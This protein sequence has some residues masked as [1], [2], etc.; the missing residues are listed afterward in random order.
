[1]LDGSSV[2]ALRGLALQ[3]EEA[4]GDAWPVAAEREVVLLGDVAVALGADAAQLVEVLGARA[5]EFVE[6]VAAS[7][8]GVG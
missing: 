5:A 8:S 4:A 1:M 7:S 6:A 2:V 3:F